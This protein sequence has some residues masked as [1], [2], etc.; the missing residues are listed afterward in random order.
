[1]KKVFVSGCFDL[2]HSGHAKFL[3]EAARFGDVIVGIGSDETV[4]SLKGR[5]PVN[6]ELERKYM[7]ES[8]K[9]VI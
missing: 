1:M 5:Y 3:S 7:L 6:N 2:L 4:N 9:S 8:L